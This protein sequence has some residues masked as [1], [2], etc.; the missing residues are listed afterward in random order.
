MS[1]H[2][3]ESGH[4]KFLWKWL[5]RDFIKESEAIMDWH[6]LMQRQATV[7]RILIKG[8]RNETLS[9]AYLFIGQKGTG[10]LQAARLLAKSFFCPH[11]EGENPCDICPDC[12]RVDS[13]NHPDLVLVQPDGKSIKK[14]QV[15]GLIK[16]FSYK[17]MESS[18]KFFII[19]SA[20]SMTT[21]AANSL[22]KFIEEPQNETIAVLITE[23]QHQLLDTI[24]SRCQTLTFSPLLSKDLEDQLREK[25]YGFTI[26]RVSSVITQNIDEAELLCQQDWFAKAC[27][28]VINLM[29]E[30]HSR[31]DQAFIYLYDQ[32]IP[33][34][35][36]QD[37]APLALGL[38]LLWLRD[39]MNA[40]LGHDEQIVFKDQEEIIKDQALRSSLTNLAEQMTFVMSATKRLG[41]N[42]QFTSVLEQ[43]LYR[44]QGGL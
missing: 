39:C 18:K 25:G 9:H 13:G 24:V 4:C 43:L 8:L 17:G 6:S 5:R 28:I 37:Q 31:P 14:E 16:E 11:R 23:S 41:S 44:L 30:A 26:S 35:Q 36:E 12:R 21:Q 7:G 1:T 15:T 22:L 20:E 34:F 33:L 29:K 27:S 42:V 10:K 32:V 38:I 3:K 40:H 2:L 19:E